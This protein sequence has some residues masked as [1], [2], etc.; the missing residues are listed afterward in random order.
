MLPGVTSP[1]PVEESCQE[2]QRLPWLPDCAQRSSIIVYLLIIYD[3]FMTKIVVVNEMGIH[4][5]T[6]LV[7]SHKGSPGSLRRCEV[8]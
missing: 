4:D 1:D 7:I 6:N 5:E 2:S 3:I 8:H